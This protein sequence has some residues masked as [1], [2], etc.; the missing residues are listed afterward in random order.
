MDMFTKLSLTPWSARCETQCG[1]SSCPMCY[2]FKRTQLKNARREE[3]AKQMPVYRG[4]CDICGVE[5]LPSGTGPRSR[6]LYRVGPFKTPRAW[7]CTGCS[8][9]IGFSGRSARVLRLQADFLDR[10]EGQPLQ[11]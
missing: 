8:K 7:I 5:T 11:T 9:S 1:K 3:K 6:R 10:L 2:R 4:C